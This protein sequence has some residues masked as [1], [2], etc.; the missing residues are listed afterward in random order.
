MLP[1]T[2]VALVAAALI[3]TAVSAAQTAGQ[4]YLA[5]VIFNWLRKTLVPD[6]FVSEVK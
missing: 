4:L 5:D 6:G 3:L 2:K 1:R